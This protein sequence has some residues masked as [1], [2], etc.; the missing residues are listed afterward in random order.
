MHK[1]KFIT[2]ALA[3]IFANG[4]FAQKTETQN[5]QEIQLG[6]IRHQSLPTDLLKRIRA[7]T[8]LFEPVDGI[9][10]DAAVDLY[11]RDLHPEQNLVL[12]EEMARAYEYFCKSRC[13]ATTEKQDVY[14]TLLLRTMFEDDEVKRRVQVKVLKPQ[15]VEVIIKLYKL[16]PMPIEVGPGMQR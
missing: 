2:L 12:F 3:L 4:V 16:P 13:T 5:S 11:K 1:R 9:S 6:P 15:E 8:D 10:F 14:Q 7:V